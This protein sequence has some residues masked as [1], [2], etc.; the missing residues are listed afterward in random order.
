MTPSRWQAVAAGA[1][2]L[3]ALA[4]GLGPRGPAAVDAPSEPQAGPAA[5]APPSGGAGFAGSALRE[6]VVQSGAP[7]STPGLQKLA[8]A[9]DG[10]VEAR[11]LAQG[12]PRL[13]AHVRLYLR[14]RADPNTGQIDWRFAGAADSGAGGIARIAAKPGVYLLAARS[15][16]F[17]PARLEFQRPAGEPLTRVS[18]ELQ[19]GVAI[20][21]RTVQKGTQEAVPLALVVLTWEA[22]RR[23]GAPAEEQAR[24]SSDARGKFR[25]DGLAPGHYRASAQAAGYARGAAR[26]D[27]QVSR[28]VVVELAAASFIEGHVVAADGSPGAGAEVSATGGEDAVTTAASETGSFSLEVSP[29]SW[30]LTARRGD[31]AGRAAAPVAVA[32]GATARGVKIQLGAA[33]GLSGTVVAAASQQPIAGAQIAVSP[34][35]ANGDSGRAVSDGSGAFKVAGLAPGS[36]DVEVSAD[37]FTDQSRRGVTVQ[38]GQQFPLRV[39]LRRTGAIEGVV[40]DSQGRPVPYALVRA[41]RFGFGPP[42]PSLEARS[43]DSGAYRLS[44]LAPGAGSFTALRDGS[45]QGATASAEVPE[46]G[47]ARLDF[48][49]KDEGVVTGRV[50]RKDGSPPPADASVLAVSAAARMLHTNDSTGI[51]LDATGLYLASLPAG[52]YSLFVQGSAN[53]FGGRTFVTVE[54]GKTATQDLTYADAAED[55]QGFGGTVLEPDGT[56]SPNALVRASGGNLF[57]VINTDEQGRFHLDRPRADLPDS[58]ELVAINGG[59]S[60]KA[61]VPPRQ[62]EVTVQLQAAATLRGHLVGG[63]ADSFRVDLAPAVAGQAGSGGSQSLEFTGDRFELRD[64]PALPVHVAVATQDGRSAALEVALA[65]G[66]T[67]EIEVPLQP[68]ANLHGRL[69]DAATQQPLSGVPISVDRG[70]DTVTAADGRFSLGASAGEHALHAYLPRYRPLGKVFTA[71]AGEQLDLGEVALKPLAAQ[72]GTVGIQ[73]R[74]DSETPVSVVFLIPDGPAEKAGVQL[75]DEIVAVDGKPVASVSDAVARIQGAPGMPVQLSLRRSG[76]ALTVTI[77]RAS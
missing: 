47:A 39:E 73:L 45:A 26:I 25:I 44:G 14:G 75:G 35:G 50:R 21:G 71:Q 34:Y 55:A 66:E 40:R 15:E 16:T 23:P 4:W 77:V 67:R 72:S 46:G 43:D 33:S 41:L 28:E 57:F 70:E 76:T 58:F 38:A 9:D 60:G 1:I 49:L 51:P 22:S 59:R 62:S 11:V 3:L 29:R 5:R 13:G 56:P 36:Y 52:A 31:E 19:P 65:P 69:V 27:A 6:A 64:V 2:L 42:A 63:G 17:A 30:S 8:S 74:G 18:V 12:K 61:T 7:G 53:G 32:A 54:A 10:F 68:L 24:T 20:S 48:Q 37:G